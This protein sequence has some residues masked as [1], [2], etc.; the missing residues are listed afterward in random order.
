[1]SGPAN[2]ILNGLLSQC[3]HSLI[4][5]LFLSLSSCAEAILAADFNQLQA[6]DPVYGGT[7]L[8]WAKT[9]EVSGTSAD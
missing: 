8:H 3:T 1:M 5:S 4:L 2:F 7:P 6:E 9:A